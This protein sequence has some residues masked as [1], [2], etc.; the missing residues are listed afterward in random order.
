MEPKLNQGAPKAAR[1]E[2]KRTQGAPKGAK[3]EPK[4]AKRE[5]MG[6]QKASKNP[7]G[8]QGRFWERKGGVPP[9]VFGSH[10]GT[11]FYQK[12]DQNRCKNRCPKN[13]IFHKKPT[14]KMCEN[15][16]KIHENPI[17]SRKGVFDKSTIIDGL[18]AQNHDWAPSK[19]IKNDQRT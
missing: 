16:Y 2:L 19:N 4:G 8:R 6:D 3:R 7:L 10:F 15:Q 11:I 9:R 1:R 18:F 13:M 5:P 12:V 17:F 14:P